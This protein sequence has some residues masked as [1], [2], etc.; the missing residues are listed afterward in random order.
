LSE[1]R[2]ERNYVRVLLWLCIVA[3]LGVAVVQLTLGHWS[4][5]T[6]LLLLLGVVNAAS[7]ATGRH[8]ERHPGRLTRLHLR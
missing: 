3:P 2:T 1:H 5:E 8:G 4:E 7:W 6:W